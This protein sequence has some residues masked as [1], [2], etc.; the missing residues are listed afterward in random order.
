MSGVFMDIDHRMVAF[1]KI[2]S[3]GP[4]KLYSVEDIKDVR[5]DS[6]PYFDWNKR[7]V[8]LSEGTHEYEIVF[9]GGSYIEP[10]FPAVL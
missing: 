10:H 5:I 7:T 2:M 9:E 6:Q 8:N 4:G 1:K 3:T